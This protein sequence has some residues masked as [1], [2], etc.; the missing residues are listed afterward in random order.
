M[1]A[2]RSTIETRDGEVVEVVK[3]HELMEDRYKN[4]VDVD[5]SAPRA[6]V[7]MDVGTWGGANFTA[8]VSIRLTCAQTKAKLDEAAELG[9][10][11]AMDYLKDAWELLNTKFPGA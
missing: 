2:I 1:N 6:E 7:A 5:P 9:F 4:L 8:K 11:T 3:E 10:T